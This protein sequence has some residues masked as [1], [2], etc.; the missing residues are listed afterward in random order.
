MK[1]FLAVFFVLMVVNI[2]FAHAEL[3]RVSEDGVNELVHKIAD[4]IYDEQFQKEKPLLITNFSKFENTEFPEIGKEAWV[5]QFGLKT[6]DKPDGEIVFFVDAEEKVSSLKIVG[7]SEQSVEN[8]SIV[9][10]VTL[11]ALGLPQEDI[12]FL[13]TNLNNDEVLPSSIVWSEK[14]HC[15]FVLM[16][17]ARPN[18]TEGFQFVVMATDKNE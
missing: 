2:S 16:A 4:T 8:A 18:S 7:H 12:E 1:K 15:C 9:L 11:R 17:G 3:L 13:M 5:G 6:A 10:F 14:K